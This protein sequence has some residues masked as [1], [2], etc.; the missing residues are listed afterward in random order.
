VG[1]PTRGPLSVDAFLIYVAGVA[2][3]AIIWLFYG[4]IHMRA[5]RSGLAL[6]GYGSVGFSALFTLVLLV[7]A[8][9]R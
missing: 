4:L 7:V 2:V 8:F 9:I 6:I 5:P 3:Y 1:D